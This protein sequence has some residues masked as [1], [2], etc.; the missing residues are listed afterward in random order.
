MVFYWI[1]CKIHSGLQ[2]KK[3]KKSEPD[4]SEFQGKPESILSWF[5]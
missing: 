4:G 3:K 2:K 5:M 1:V